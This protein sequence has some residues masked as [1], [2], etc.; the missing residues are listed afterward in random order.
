M[1]RTRS[2]NMNIHHK[3]MKQLAQDIEQ[4]GQR[5][6]SEYG[7]FEVNYTRFDTVKKTWMVMPSMYDWYCKFMEQDLDLHI[8]PRLIPGWR[9][10]ESE[11]L[12]FQN[13][14]KFLNKKDVSN[15][16][17][18]QIVSEIPYGFEM[19]AVS[20]YQRLTKH[21]QIPLE[22]ALRNLS[23]HASC[24]LKM[25][26]NLLLDFRG[27]ESIPSAKYIVQTEIPYQKSNFKGLILTAKEQLYIEY[28]LFN[29]TYKEIAYQQRCSET[30]VRKV[31]FNIKRKLGCEH[32]PV[33]KLLIKLNEYGVLSQMSH[34][35]KI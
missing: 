10:W 23:Y 7:V 2:I 4:W 35:F 3:N 21:E 11:D 1:Q 34:K 5:Y 29:L 30:A 16:N 9:F 28:M 24:V 32:L 19:L 14:Q 20:S 13:Y 15:P 17:K 26:P 25:K 18:C 27:A 22:R 31:V 6:L 8:A 33:S 12:T